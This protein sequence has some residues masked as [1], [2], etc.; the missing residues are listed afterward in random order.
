MREL[1]LVRTIHV[2][3]EDLIVPVLVGVGVRDLRPVERDVEPRGTERSRERLP[4]SGADADYGQRL[5]GF[6]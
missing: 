4:D 2:H 1:P 5:L 3:H 6:V